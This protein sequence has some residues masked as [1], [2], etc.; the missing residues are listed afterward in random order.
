MIVTRHDNNLDYSC[1]IIGILFH[2]QL[3]NETVIHYSSRLNLIMRL[4]ISISRN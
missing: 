3:K 4:F 2:L 1:Q